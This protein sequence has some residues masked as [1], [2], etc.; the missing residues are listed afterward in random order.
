MQLSTDCTLLLPCLSCHT[1][2]VP[3]F[4]LIARI[5]SC[6][7]SCWQ[8]RAQFLPEVLSCPLC[9]LL[10]S[11]KPQRNEKHPAHLQKFLPLLQESGQQHPGSQTEILEAY[12]EKSLL[13]NNINILLGEA[14]AA[15]VLVGAAAS[16]N[17]EAI[18]QAVRASAGER[19]ESYA[20][21]AF[22]KCIPDCL[23]WTDFGL[24]HQCRPSSLQELA[25]VKAPMAPSCHLPGHAR[26]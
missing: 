15:P 1:G 23:V 4:T 22:T 11:P 10:L 18:V 25:G 14:S 20:K 24:L 5:N 9:Y 6:L 3:Y 12:F 8:H 13:G 16:F 19:K 2:L 26:G 17:T 7:C 21:H